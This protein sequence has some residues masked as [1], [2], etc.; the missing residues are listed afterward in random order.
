MRLELKTR[1]GGG[2]LGQSIP[3]P[4][5][6]KRAIDGPERE[7]IFRQEHPP[8][9]QGLSDFTAAAELA[10]TVAG[11]AFRRAFFVKRSGCSS[12]AFLLGP[13]LLFDPRRE[14]SSVPTAWPLRRSAQGLSRLA[15]LCRHP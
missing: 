12:F 5:R 6:I 3:S 1:A 14:H 8:G 13:I 10:V 2:T 9:W 15:A 7:L 11:M 4:R